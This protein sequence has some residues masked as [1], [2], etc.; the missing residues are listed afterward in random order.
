MTNHNLDQDRA[1]LL[2]GRQKT[3]RVTVPAWPRDDNDLPLV[4]LPVEWPMFSTLNHR[5]RAEQLREISA[6]GREDLFTRDPLGPEAQD[7]QYRILHS[8]DGFD[9]L[10]EDLQERGQQEPAIITADGILINGN[11]RT[12]A[13]RSLYQ[14]DG[15]LEAQYVRCLVLPRDATPEELVDLETELQ[16]AKDFKQEYSWV[17][18][19]LLIEE[20][21]DRADK[22]WDRVAAR[23][24]RAI[25][26]VRGMYEKLQQLHQLVELSN[27]AR[28]HVDFLENESVF[29]ELAK[30]IKNKSPQESE[31]VRA[32]YF[33]GVL[34]GAKYRDLRHLKRSDAAT[35][36][37]SEIEGDAAL[38]PIL[39]AAEA[40]ATETLEDDPLSELLGNSEPP[41]SLHNLLS[42]VATKRPGAT[43]ALSTGEQLL[44]QDALKSISSSITAA[45]DEAK[46][47]KRD[48]NSLKAPL[49]RADKAI[50][51][52]ER[53]LDALPRARAFKEEWDEVALAERIR[54][55]RQLVQRIE[56]IP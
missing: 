49:E 37:R 30:H 33:L 29:D 25:N 35:L 32:V 19:A 38:K 13:L 50:A 5:T 40:A 51:E 27:G 24:H 1:A 46:E 36:V 6:T 16:V 23:M 41:S 34:T 3:K 55:I 15:V 43:V 53:V 8:Q 20:H 9:Q 11:R 54:I 21:Y 48:Q 31:A 14:E 39:E 56:L 42:F 17:N 7:A 28:L 45:A 26:D 44:V 18:E 2:E 4:Q 12:A 10:K 52:L 22:N 47:E